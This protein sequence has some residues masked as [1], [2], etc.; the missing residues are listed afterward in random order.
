MP[1][2][3]EPRRVG[4]KGRRR[5][6]TDGRS[7]AVWLNGRHAT[8]ARCS[9]RRQVSTRTIERGIES[10]V[11]YLGRVAHAIG[12]CERVMILGPGTDRLALEREYVAIN[13]RPDRHV[14]VEP[15][16]P[17]D[18]SELVNRVRELAG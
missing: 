5:G 17:V 6:S 14:H 9:S 8:L 10:Q 2:M 18:V 12:D 1:S 15:A 4:S 11:V 13:H 16:G 7:A 3:L